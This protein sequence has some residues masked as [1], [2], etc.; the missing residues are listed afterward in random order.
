M[1]ALGGVPMSR[2][3]MARTPVCCE[4]QDGWVSGVHKNRGV[5]RCCGGTEE[6]PGDWRRAT[7]W[8][9]SGAGVVKWSV[10]EQ[11]SNLWLKQ[12]SQEHASRSGVVMW[13][14]SRRIG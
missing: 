14:L 9:C 11:R 6:P 13:V 12:R 5:R 10:N 8:C 7:K 2:Q 1:D 4:L 3:W